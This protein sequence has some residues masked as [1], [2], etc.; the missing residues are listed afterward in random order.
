MLTY[1]D[2]FTKWAEAFPM[3][4]K[5]T[6]TIG[7]VLVEQ[8]FTHFGVPLSILSDQGKEVDGKVMQEVCLLFGI[9]KLRTTAYKPS[10]NIVEHFHSTMNSVLAKIVTSH[11]RDW[12]CRLPFAMAAYRASRYNS[13][14]T[15]RTY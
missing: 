6:E 11:Q 10:T 14:G 1:I 8:V 5:E 2:S 3:R 9:E 15:C 4:N 13:T 12:D 7:K